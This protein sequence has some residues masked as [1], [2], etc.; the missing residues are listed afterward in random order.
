MS[1]TA[2]DVKKLREET[3]AG[4]MD[5]KKA[6]DE[7][8]GDFA[9]AKEIVRQKGLARAEKKADRET[10]EGYIASYVHTNRKLGVLL[11]MLCETDFVARNEEFQKMANDIAMHTAVMNPASVEELLTQEFVRDPDVTIE[12][13][14]K[15]LSG[16]IGEK[17]VLHR[18]T[19]YEVGADTE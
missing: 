16:K 17:F 11:E 12:N 10:K 5:C 19:R 18:F 14:I 13:M 15:E 3:G 4:M 8:Q 6:L 9:K 7:A 1:F 2:S